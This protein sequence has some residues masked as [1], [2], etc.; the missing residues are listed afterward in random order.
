MSIKT[1]Q[2]IYEQ[3]N[4]RFSKIKQLDIALILDTNK[5]D[6]INATKACKYNKKK[7]FSYWKNLK[8]AKS[9]IFDLQEDLGLNSVMYEL[10]IR[11]NYIIRKEISLIMKNGRYSYEEKKF[12]EQGNVNLVNDDTSGTYVHEDLIPII[13]TWHSNKYAIKMSRIIKKINNKREIRKTG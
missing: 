9:L 8:A 5:G 1:R 13:M 7:E 11:K 3:I 2:I 10:E 4:D 6:F 12:K